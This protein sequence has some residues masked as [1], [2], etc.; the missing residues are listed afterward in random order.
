[1]SVSAMRAAKRQPEPIGFERFEAAQHLE[2]PAYM[3]APCLDPRDKSRKDELAQRP[4]EDDV[5][6]ESQIR[7][8]LGAPE[9]EP[10][11]DRREP[12]QI[13]QEFFLTRTEVVLAQT[14]LAD[15]LVVAGKSAGIRPMRCFREHSLSV[16]GKLSSIKRKIPI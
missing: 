2:P 6:G 9:H 12:L 3:R 7:H 13:G 16:L 4:V 11:A 5:G 8:G 14:S 1:M 15:R 10:L